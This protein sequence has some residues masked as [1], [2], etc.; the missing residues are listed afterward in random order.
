ME[1]N[2]SRKVLLDREQSV[3]PSLT[4]SDKNTGKNMSL[5]NRMAA[6]TLYAT[7]D[8]YEAQKKMVLRA[9]DPVKPSLVASHAKI[10]ANLG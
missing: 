10:R 8:K 5:L 7:L 9:V 4:V 2:L 3:K 6:K 1:D